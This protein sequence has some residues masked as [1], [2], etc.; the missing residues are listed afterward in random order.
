MELWEALSIRRKEIGMSFDELHGKSG[1]S[2]STLKKIMGGH[3]AAPSY[4]SIRQITSAMGLTMEELDVRIEGKKQPSVEKTS[5]VMEP[6][7]S[8][9]AF[10][11]AYD[12]LTETGKQLIDQMMEFAKQHHSL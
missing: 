12:S 1:L 3:V 7:H 5:G 2:V 6:S 8:A 4:D 9:I 11:V 10:A